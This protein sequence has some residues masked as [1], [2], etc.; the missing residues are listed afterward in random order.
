[1]PSSPGQVTE[2]LRGLQDKDPQ[3]ASRLLPLVYNE[4]RRL[5][6]H[7]MRGEKPGQ[8]I[9]ATE[10]VH[11]AY[12]RLVGQARIEWQGRSHFLAMAATSMRR[13]LVERARKKL[14]E[15]HGG[16]EQKVQLDEALVFSPEKSKDIVALDDALKRLEKISPRQSRVVE[17][18]FFGGLEMEEIAH[19]EGVSVRTVK[20]DWS[21]A[22]AWLHHEIARAK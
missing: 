1:M 21:L 16:G 10:L 4:L 13:I 8:T 9:Q 20:Q 7:Y 22:R 5:A 19:V 6:A 11:E 17:L 15:K 2:L 12:L 3:A 14:A 18:R